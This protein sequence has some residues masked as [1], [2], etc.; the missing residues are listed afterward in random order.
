MRIY[1]DETQGAEHIVLVKGD[2]SG[3]EPV[4][5]RMHAMDPLLDVVGTGPK[6]RA[7]SSATRCG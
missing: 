2:I 3:P 4:L 1:T 5:V 7:A 6:G